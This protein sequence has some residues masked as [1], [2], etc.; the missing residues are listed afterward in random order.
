MSHVIAC[1]AWLDSR[2]FF[3]CIDCHKHGVEAVCIDAN[4]FVAHTQE[5]LQA[6]SKPKVSRTSAYSRE[7]DQS[8][9]A[10]QKKPYKETMVEVE[11]EIAAYEKVIEMELEKTQ[12]SRELR[13][14]PERCSKR[15]TTTKSTNGSTAQGTS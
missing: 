13:K 1:T 9:D 12:W 2:A 5:H 10:P 14:R 3:K 7:G 4:D 6:P 11:R 8:H 15:T